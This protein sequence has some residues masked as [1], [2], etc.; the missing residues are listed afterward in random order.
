MIDIIN[1]KNL[2]KKEVKERVKG[3]TD[4]EQSGCFIY[5][6]DTLLNAIDLIKKESGKSVDSNDAKKFENIS[7][8]IIDS[9]KERDDIILN[10]HMLNF[11]AFMDYLCSLENNNMKMQIKGVAFGDPYKIDGEYKNELWNFACTCDG[12][13]VLCFYNNGNSGNKFAPLSFKDFKNDMDLIKRFY[14]G[15]IDT[16][17]FEDLLNKYLNIKGER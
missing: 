5:V 15:D 7:N 14:L 2:S 16:L 13:N 1:F 6:E 10:K 12:L 11:F 9:L 4:P 8:K 3:L 17:E